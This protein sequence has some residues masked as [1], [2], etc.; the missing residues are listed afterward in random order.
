MCGAAC[1]LHACRTFLKVVLTLG[2]LGAAAAG[3]A[4]AVKKRRES[5]SSS[6]GQKKPGAKDGKAA[7]APAAPATKRL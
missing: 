1:P 6:G 7:P 5:S 4:V 3:A 2:V